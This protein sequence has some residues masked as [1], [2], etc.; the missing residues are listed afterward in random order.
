MGERC[1][2]LPVLWEEARGWRLNVEE[3]M[4]W[5]SGFTLGRTTGAMTVALVSP[6]R[7]YGEQRRKSSQK[8]TD[9]SVNRGTGGRLFLY[10]GVASPGQDESK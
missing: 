6:R 1:V 7:N 10:G 3:R 8:E 9:G 2:C 5:L 4:P